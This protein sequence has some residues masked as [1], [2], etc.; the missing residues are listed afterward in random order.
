MVIPF[1]NEPSP[2]P[3][4]CSSVLQGPLCRGPASPPVI[5]TLSC[6]IIK[7]FIHLFRGH[8]VH[9]CVCLLSYTVSSLDVP[10][11]AF[12]LLC[13]HLVFASTHR[14]HIRA[15]CLEVMTLV[16]SLTVIQGTR[17]SIIET[18]FLNST[19]W[20]TVLH[21]LQLSSYHSLDSV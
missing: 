12:L 11:F 3:S 5:L 13:P 4:I 2:Q 17:C 15:P 8:S 21:R 14:V 18:H 19:Q 10:F 16:K 9:L 20:K 6:A 7:P 1:L